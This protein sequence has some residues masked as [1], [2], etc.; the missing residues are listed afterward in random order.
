MKLI[1]PIGP[2]G[3]GKTTFSQAIPGASVASFADP[4]YAAMSAILGPHKV[5]ELRRL[6]QKGEPLVELGGKSLRFALRSL[7]TEWGRNMIWEDIWC[8]S[9]FRQYDDVDVLTIDDLRFPNEYEAARKRG[10]VFVRIWQRGYERVPPEHESESY[11]FT[12]PVHLQV[13]WDTRDEIRDKAGYV[14]ER[15]DEIATHRPEVTK[16]LVPTLP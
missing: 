16:R 3:G 12:F 4:L 14:F 13:E 5:N 6:N 1:I 10:A 11:W 8:E 7:G 15:L 2:P 9:L